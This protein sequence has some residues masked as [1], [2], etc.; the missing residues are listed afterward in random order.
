[1]SGDFTEGILV[2][3]DEIIY[4]KPLAVFILIGIN[5]IFDQ[6]EDREK[7]TPQYVANNIN[8]IAK[9]IQMNTKD[10]KIFIQTILPVD[11]LLFMKF[12]NRTLPV[13]R[14]SLNDQIKQ[15]NTLI[16]KNNN[17]DIID[18]HSVFIDKRGLMNEK[19]TTDGVHLNDLGYSIWVN[20]IKNDILSMNK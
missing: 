3:L 15:I 10:T 2:R 8:Q 1:I 5:D 16:K 6:H 9:Q 20:N 17:Y 13:Y 14:T 12:H 11:T 18:L 4:Y 19:Y 7:I